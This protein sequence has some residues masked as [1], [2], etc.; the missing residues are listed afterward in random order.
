[1]EFF[2][3]EISDL[4]D[5]EY[6]RAFVRFFGGVQIVNFDQGFLKQLV[7]FLLLLNCR[8]LG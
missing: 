5:A 6:R 3:G 4:R 1:M 2:G 8:V 7:S